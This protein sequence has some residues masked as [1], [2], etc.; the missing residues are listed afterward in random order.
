MMS[1]SCGAGVFTMRIFQKAL[2]LSTPRR[3]FFTV[4]TAYEIKSRAANDGDIG[5]KKNFVRT[6]FP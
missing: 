2:N 1:T 3:Q 4:A 5:E 6:N